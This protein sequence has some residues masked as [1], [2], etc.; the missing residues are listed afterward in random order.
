MQKNSSMTNETTTNS[1]FVKQR[2]FFTSVLH[3]H[4]F[5]MI[6]FKIGLQGFFYVY[7]DGRNPRPIDLTTDH[8]LHLFVDTALG[9]LLPQNARVL[10]KGHW[11]VLGEL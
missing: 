6:L 11:M 5:C 1:L 2:A 7:I 8:W 3:T 9:N 4:R 10:L